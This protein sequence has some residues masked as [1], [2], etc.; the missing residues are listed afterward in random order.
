[1]SCISTSSHQSPPRNNPKDWWAQYSSQ[2][3][4]EDPFTLEKENRAQWEQRHLPLNQRQTG[5]EFYAPNT[6]EEAIQEDVIREG[7][8]SIVYEQDEIERARKRI[9]GKETPLP[10][11]TES[12]TINWDEILQET[13]EQKKRRRGVSFLTLAGD[14]L[15]VGAAPTTEKKM[16]A[17]AGAADKMAALGTTAADAREK[18]I[19][20]GKVLE[21]VYKGREQEKGRQTRKS[22]EE[23]AKIKAEPDKASDIFYASLDISRKGGKLKDKDWAYALFRATGDTVDVATPEDMPNIEGNADLPEVKNKTYVINGNYYKIDSKTGRLKNI[24]NET[25]AKFKRT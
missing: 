21:K 8:D 17:L 1:V 20:Q 7:G 4:P 12:D 5:A 2:T 15:R 19:L 25:L 10:I 22:A 11:D 13:P 18:A 9:S 3:T 24:H 16:T 14:A 23:A 6:E